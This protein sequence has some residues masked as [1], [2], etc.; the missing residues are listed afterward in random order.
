MA[1]TLDSVT[2]LPPVRRFITK[3]NA[4]GKSVHLESTPQ[5]YFPSPGAGGYARSYSLALPGKL[6]DNADIKAYTATDNVTSWNSPAIVA[7]GGA[8]LVVVDLVPGGQS[9]M[10]QTVSLDFS[11]VVLGEIEHEL[12]SGEIVTLKAGV[13][14]FFREYYNSAI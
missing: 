3:H 12:D 2:S 13:S 5:K 4:D 11:V 14:P 10:H 7:P 9:L 8:N 1:E 6:A